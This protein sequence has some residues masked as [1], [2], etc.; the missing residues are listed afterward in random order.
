MVPDLWLDRDD[1]P[2]AM[3]LVLTRVS[4]RNQ[5]YLCDYQK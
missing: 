2:D 3:G 5:I 4:R 1:S